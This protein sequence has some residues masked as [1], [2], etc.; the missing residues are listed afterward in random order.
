MNTFCLENT[1][2]KLEFE[3]AHGALV[4]VTALETGWKILDRPQVGLGVRLLLPLSEEMRN[5]PVY[6][7]KQALTRLELRPTGAAR[8]SFGMG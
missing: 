1:A 4:G 7:E 6:G 8:F 5:N 3:R 2:L